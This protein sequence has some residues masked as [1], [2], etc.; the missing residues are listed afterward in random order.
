MTPENSYFDRVN[1]NLLRL[2][3]PDARVVVE[4]GCG[5]GA[6]GET[7]KRIN[8]HCTY[9]GIEVNA[10]VAKIAQTRLDR[11]ISANVETGDDA[12]LGIEP[13][14]VDCLVYGD[15]LEHLI[16]PW[17]TLKHHVSWLKPDGQVVASIPNIGHWTMIQELLK[18]Q[19]QYQ[20]EGLL[21]RTHLRFF[22]FASIQELF[23]YAGLK[24][25]NSAKTLYD[26]G[27]GFEQF[28]KQ[29]APMLEAMQ[30]NPAEV[31]DQTRAFQYLVCGVKAQL[32]VRPLLV[33]T[34]MMAPLACDRVRVLEPDQFSATIPGVRPVSSEKTAALNIAYPQEEKVFI[35]QRAVLTP[36]AIAKQKNLIDR[37]YLVI[38][39]MDDDPMRWPIHAQTNFFTYQSCHCV[40]TSTEPLATFLRQ[41]NPYVAVFPNQLGALPVPKPVNSGEQVTIFFGALNREQ[42]WEP[43]MDSI[44]RVVTKYIDRVKFYV[45][46]DKKFFD[47]LVTP[48]K[49]FEAFSPYPRY[50]D[51]LYASD[52]TILPLLPTRFNSMKSDLKFLECAGHGVAVL[53]S[54][55][56]YERSISDGETGLIYRS[57]EEFESKLE[58]LIANTKL[59][60]TLAQNAYEWVKNNRLLSQHYRQRKDWYL[61][62]RDRLP[63]LNAA[64]KERIPELF[65]NG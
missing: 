11:A 54:P 16:D 51:I 46:H 58:A 21:D 55:V 60:Q 2:I 53:A 5:T 7:Y 41:H 33:Q 34:L 63:E 15:V 52:L 45:L 61:E 13:E 6:L 47:A 57:P 32:S 37:G 42:D 62:M 64:L 8:P 36:Q 9:I 38:A 1:H 49:T 22:T 20:N 65:G 35:W 23:S 10:E 59:R 40:Q 4:I 43:L 29:I 30:L 12:T 39:E 24:I 28:Q 56:V 31:A 18:G 48:N 26:R 44:N 50:K 3:P 19:W 14:S 25:H 27:D 17:K